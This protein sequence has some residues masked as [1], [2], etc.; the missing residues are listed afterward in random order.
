MKLS[1]QREDK[2]HIKEF[3]N[4]VDSTYKIV[5]HTIDGSKQTRV[6]ITNHEFCKHLVSKGMVVDK[7]ST[8]TSPDVD[9]EYRP[10]FIRGFFD[11]DGSFCVTDLGYQ[12]N[13]QWSIAAKSRRRLKILHRWLS[14]MCISGGSIYSYEYISN[15]LDIC[16]KKDCV[17][18]WDTLYP[19]DF[20]TEPSLMRKTRKLGRFVE[21]YK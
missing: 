12:T 20:S 10:E 21:D 6:A 19:S 7:S 8:D 5:D 11:G 18:I 13:V 3:T 16:G 15:R 14:N 17:A 9:E 4:E 1:L 2:G